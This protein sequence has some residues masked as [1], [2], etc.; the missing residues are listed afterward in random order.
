MAAAAMMRAAGRNAGLLAAAAMLAVLAA[1]ALTGAWPKGTSLEQVSAGGI[2]APR[3][4]GIARVEVSEGDTAF[5]FAR[6]ADGVWHGDRAPIPQAVAEHVEAA[7]HL[8]HVS[9]PRRVLGPG[10]Y[11]AAKL[12]E[13]G[14]DPPRMMITLIGGDGARTS[15]AF[16]EATPA[17]NSQYARR[18]GT[19]DVVLLSRYVGT[20]WEI[21]LDMALRTAAPAAED[22]ARP[23]PSALLLPVSMAEI[24]VVEI[25]ENGALTRFERDPAG[26]WFH[27][28]GQHVHG[29]GGLVHKADPKLAPLIA[30]ELAALEQASVEGV[31]TQHPAAEALAQFGL[32]HASS[33]MILYTRDSS[34]PVARVEFG[35]TSDDGFAR[36]ARVRETDT[37]VTVPRY[38]A[39]HVSRLLQLAGARS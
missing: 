31:V 13:F 22:A 17:A 27:H 5:R 15:L 2:V 7:I 38:S 37:V 6:A 30:A 10:E 25:L 19:P 32:D 9:A 23:R 1:I 29:P 36:Y 21:A 35:R 34:R 24:A 12:A 18:I 14:L 20:E 26:E 33:I 11:D 3:P 8:L 4:A 16:G 39:A 28:V